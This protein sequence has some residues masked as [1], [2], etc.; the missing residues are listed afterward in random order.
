MLID[1]DKSVDALLNNEVLA[2]PTEAVFGL[3]SKLV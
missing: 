1:F 3:G 2:Y